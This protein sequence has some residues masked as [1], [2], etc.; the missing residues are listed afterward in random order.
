[1]FILDFNLLGRLIMNKHTSIS[2]RNFVQ[3]ASTAAVT[4]TA[5]S[6]KRVVGANETIHVALIGCGGRGTHDMAV[7]KRNGANV[8]AVC[9][10]DTSHMER[11]RETAGGEPVKM[12]KD[13]RDVLA[14]SDVDAVIIGTPDHW[15]ALP[16]VEACKAGKDVYC[17]KPL[18]V[19]IYEGQMMVQ[20]ARK[21]NRVTQCGTQQHSGEHYKEAVQLIQEGHIGDVTKV[22]CWNAYNGN[23]MG[24]ANITE[25]PKE[26]DWDLWLGPTPKTPY[27]LQRSHGSFRS[28]WDYSGGVMTDWGTHHLD[29]VQWALDQKAPNSIICEGGRYGNADCGETPDTQD[30][31]LK[32][33]GCNVHYSLRTNSAFYSEDPKLYRGYGILFYGK[34]AT[35]FIDRD[36]YEIYPERG[37]FGEGVESVVRR[38]ERG[39]AN[40]DDSH[41]QDFLSKIKTRERCNADVEI[42]H[43]S[44]SAP[45]LANIALRSGERVV[46]DS[47]NERITNHLEL[48]SWLKREYRQ[49]WEL[50]L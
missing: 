50:T 9:D 49:P 16:F 24:E 30:A 18:C 39:E 22:Y 32:Y 41:V 38:L 25:P 5:L 42:C 46:W 11:A 29:I 35:L 8:L 3:T 36:R 10:A 40:L 31:I 26:L 20:A 34:K 12:V 21:Y 7:F 2:R 37:D 15:H 14:M 23:G 19:F 4:M 28:F 33:D 1:L 47:E 45:H 13:F 48:N 6:A 43:R 17:E 27:F 44:T